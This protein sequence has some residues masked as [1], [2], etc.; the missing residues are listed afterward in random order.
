MVGHKIIIQKLEQKLKLERNQ[1]KK[2]KK[3]KKIFLSNQ[4]VDFHLNS[5]LSKWKAKK[6]RDSVTKRQPEA[7]LTSSNEN[8]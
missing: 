6:R 3:F 7:D 8:S 2:K 4:S 1:K 5:F